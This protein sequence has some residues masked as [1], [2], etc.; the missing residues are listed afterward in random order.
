MVRDLSWQMNH[1]RSKY[2]QNKNE[3]IMNSKS[4]RQMGIYNKLLF[5]IENIYL[6]F[7]RMGFIF[8]KITIVKME[9]EI[10]ESASTTQFVYIIYNGKEYKIG[11]SK[12]YPTKRLKE[13]QTGSSS[14]LS[15][16]YVIPTTNARAV[17]KKLHKIYEAKRI[18]SNGEW[19]K[20]NNRDLKNIKAAHDKY[21]EANKTELI[22]KIDEFEGFVI[23]ENNMTAAGRAKRG[24]LKKI[25][26]LF[27]RRYTYD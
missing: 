3:T 9:N 8:S 10:D 4:E 21:K 22:D 25:S 15:L 11:M 1:R 13:L 27:S 6:F 5:L 7:Y 19:F 23:I 26:W 17:E 2:L 20:I 14:P 12:H 18:R 24:I 16:Y